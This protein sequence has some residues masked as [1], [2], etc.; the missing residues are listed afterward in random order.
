MFLIAFRCV[1]STGWK[2]MIIGYARVSTDEQNLSLQIQA[3]ERAGCERLFKDK[4]ISGRVSKRPG[5]GSCLRALAAGDILV[6][7]RLD[8]LGR[9]L[10]HLID[11]MGQFEDRKIHFRSLTE[12]FD[13]TTP[14]GRLLFHMM[15]AIA[16]FER[17]LISER[18]KAG[19][20]AARSTGKSVGRPARIAGEQ[21][22]EIL[23]LREEGASLQE[24]A[25]LYETT[26]TTIARTLKRAER[27]T[28]MQSPETNDPES[29]D[30]VD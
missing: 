7:W 1:R 22:P 10:P 5:L 18:T 15:A 11:T 13:T 14:G 8:R 23:S 24:I 12:C 19:M 4:G 27:A 16:E 29:G 30:I 26:S 21:M 9:S 20:R 17:H 6:V 25:D 28:D 3:L 2:F